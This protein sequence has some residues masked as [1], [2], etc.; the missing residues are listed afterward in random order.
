MLARPLRMPM[1]MVTETP[2]KLVQ[3]FYVKGDKSN[4]ST[5]KCN[6]M[7]IKKLEMEV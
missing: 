3:I 1:G 6:M 4:I 2:V 7:K 5:G